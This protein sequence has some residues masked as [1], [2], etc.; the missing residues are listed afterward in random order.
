MTESNEPSYYEIALT[1]RQV[2][3]AFVVVL[4]SVLA[5]FLSGVWVGRK[6]SELPSPEMQLAAATDPEE[7]QLAQLDELAFFGGANDAATNGGT[8]SEKKPASQ[9]PASQKPTRKPDLSELLNKPSSESTLSQDVGSEPPRT[10]TPPPPPP[11]PPRRDD[12]PA[13]SNERPAKPSASE[14]EGGF[15]IQ[16]FSTR[17]EPQAKKVLGQLKSGG[18]RAFMSPVEVD[19]QTMYRVRVGPF[20]ERAGAERK[21][22]EVKEKLKLDTWITAASN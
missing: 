17:D 10:A 15:I 8:A 18:F 4:G 1:N 3:I 7:D 22:R 14:N 5:A 12:K 21:A 13:T 19:G 11:P 16:V 9:K 20:R 6:N 2:L